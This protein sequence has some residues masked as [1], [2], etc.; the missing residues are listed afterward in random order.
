MGDFARIQ[1]QALEDDLGVG[2][3]S[4]GAQLRSR[5][6]CLFEDQ[7]APGQ[8]RRNLRQVET[9][10]ESRRA[11]ADDDEVVVVVGHIPEFYLKTC[12]G[13]SECGV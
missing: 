10:G 1:S 2:D 9:G 11:G 13:A 3:Q 4:A 7:R 5:V 12:K 8:F 6:M